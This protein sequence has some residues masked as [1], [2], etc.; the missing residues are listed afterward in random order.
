MEIKR[1]EKDIIRKEI[2]F[3]KLKMEKEILKNIII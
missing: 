1:M 3:M 2:L